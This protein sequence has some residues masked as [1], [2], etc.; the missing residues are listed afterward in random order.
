MTKTSRIGADVRGTIAVAATYVYFLLFAQYGFLRLLE[1]RA[2]TETPAAVMAAMGLAGLVVSL[3]TGRLLR[4]HQ[5]TSLLR[6][7]FGGAALTALIA[8]AGRGTAFYAATAALIGGFTALTTVSLAAD[9]R[10]LIRGPRPGLAVGIATGVAYLFCNVPA[11]F[12]GAPSSQAILAALAAAAG[13]L[14]I[15]R[16]AARSCAGPASTARAERLAVDYRGLG[17]V[18][19]V[20]SFLAL[21]WLDSAVFT[22]VQQTPAL[23]APTWQGTQSW[24][25]GGVH[26][27][28]AVL[29]GIALDRGHLRGLLLATFVL[30]VAAFS[31]LGGAA[32]WLFAGGPLYVFGIST[33]SV[34]LVYFPVRHGDRPGLVPVRW[35]AALLFGIAG[36]VGSA[37]GIGMAKDLHTIPRAFIVAAGALL[38]LSMLGTARPELSRLLRAHRVTAAFLLLGVVF[39]LPQWFARGGATAAPAAT[40]APVLPAAAAAAPRTVARGRA[41]YVAEGCINCHSQYVRPRSRDVELWGP[42]R[43]PDRTERPVL[44]GNR[45]QGP[46]LLN[47]GLRRSPEWNRLHLIDPRSVSPGS[48][49]PSY[50]HLFDEG[51]RRG[52]DL[53]A[54]LTSLGRELVDER[55][56]AMQAWDATTPPHSLQDG[57]ELFGR[58]C[59]PC[60]GA[61][62]RGDGPVGR[63][64]GKPAMDLLKESFWLV[65]W[66]AGAEP[67]PQALARVVKFGVPGTTMPGHETLSPQEIAD[68]VAY[69]RSLR[70]AEIATRVRSHAHQGG[71]G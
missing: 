54:Y 51:D 61:T 59:S 50:A 69:L 62:A 2:A 19:V 5:A 33:Y 45:R 12:S 46:D 58:F 14:A 25:L 38:V 64:I 47:V 30:F 60:H 65:S 11:V 8:L 34:A 10:G 21:V 37:L 32:Q 24:L 68:V 17:F 63:A 43:E 20:L 41:V 44:I 15:R 66:G 67:E 70:S 23:K 36:W 49:M 35:R 42:Y 48:R 18:T 40:A 3:A 31:L 29:A 55:Y 57:A 9:L 22:I 1:A 52:D 56:A 39:Y 53:V 4:T 6:I 13:F 28:A 71:D 16:P 26:L 7:G 27:V